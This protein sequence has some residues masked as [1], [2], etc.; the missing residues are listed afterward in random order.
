MRGKLEGVQPTRFF[1]S[2]GECIVLTYSWND[3]LEHPKIAQVKVEIIFKNFMIS[4]PRD[5]N[6]FQMHDGDL[7][8]ICDVIPR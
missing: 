2:E 5:A 6:P 4:S 3:C 1:T 8:T 7:Q